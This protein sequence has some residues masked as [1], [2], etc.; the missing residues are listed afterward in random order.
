MELPNG[1]KS[2]EQNLFELL[3]ITGIM[4]LCGCAFKRTCREILIN[5]IEFIMIRPFIVIWFSL[6]KIYYFYKVLLQEISSPK[7]EK[8]KF[9]CFDRIIKEYR[10]KAYNDDYKKLYDERFETYIKFN[11]LNNQLKFYE[12][13]QYFRIFRSTE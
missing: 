13:K 10:Q 2:F 9:D 8:L 12:N 7:P 11:H 6:K 5:M 4:F 3:L 1:V